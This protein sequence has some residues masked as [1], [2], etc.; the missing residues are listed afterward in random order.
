MRFLKAERKCDHTV[1][2]Q[3]LKRKDV[4]HKMQR[5]QKTAI[6]SMRVRKILEVEKGVYLGGEE[7]QKWCL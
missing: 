4:G 3:T 2:R 5:S 6:K 7:T 1:Q